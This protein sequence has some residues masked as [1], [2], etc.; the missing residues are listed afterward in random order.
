MTG[1][2]IQ[3]TSSI[4]FGPRLRLAREAMNLSEKEVAT[5]LHLSQKYINILENEDFKQG[6][7][8]VFIRGYIRSYARLLNISEPEI[9]QAIEQFDLNTKA[10]QA[11]TALTIPKSNSLKSRRYPRLITFFIL[12]VII[13]QVGI[14]WHGHSSDLP[15][16][17]EIGKNTALPAPIVAA[18]PIVNNNAPVLSLSSPPISATIPAIPESTDLIPKL[19][20]ANPAVL[21][22]HPAIPN[23]KPSDLSQFKMALSEPGLES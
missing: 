8:N 23:E 1:E 22:S 17:I 7:P 19:A 5:R 4:G 12:T 18:T 2:G 13:S 3:S 20:I 21:N 15:S 14:W 9:V 6:L 11:Q 16:D 10:K